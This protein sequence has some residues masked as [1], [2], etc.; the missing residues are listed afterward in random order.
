MHCVR[1]AVG[2]AKPPLPD[3]AI[4]ASHQLLGLIVAWRAE[5][6]KGEPHFTRDCSRLGCASGT[7]MRVTLGIALA[8][9]LPTL[10]GC[11]S[12][13][14]PTGLSGPYQRAVQR[15]YVD[16]YY[17]YAPRRERVEPVPTESTTPALERARTVEP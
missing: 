16:P 4:A 13:Y 15:P 5:A 12:Y 17:V 1:V 6:P 3:A 2:T 7:T 10:A 14:P 11:N 9:L 8:C